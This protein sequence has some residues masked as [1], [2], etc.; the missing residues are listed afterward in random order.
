MVG[1]FTLLAAIVVVAAPGGLRGAKS[2][3]VPAM[4]SDVRTSGGL[5]LASIFDGATGSK[6]PVAIV[7]A[8]VAEANAPPRDPCHKKT[9][10]SWS[11]LLDAFAPRSV[12]G[13]IA[14]RIARHITILI[15]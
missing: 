8:L 1:G 2:A 3:V 7:N 9:K 6:L 11:R 5:P 12:L 14:V 10:S 4:R 15:C 13:K